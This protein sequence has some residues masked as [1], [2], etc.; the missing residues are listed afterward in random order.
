MTTANT[1]FLIAKHGL[2]MSED[3]G[4]LELW[5][6][7]LSIDERQMQFLSM[8]R[9]KSER[10]YRGGKIQR[11]RAATEDEVNQHQEFLAKEGKPLMQDTD[12]RMI[13]VFKPDPGWKSLWPDDAKLHQ[14][15]YKGIGFVERGT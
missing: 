6:W 14:M 15:A 9:S 3:E 11:I 1:L 10:A 2:N 8:H 12:Q 5:M 13:I 7:N 4:C